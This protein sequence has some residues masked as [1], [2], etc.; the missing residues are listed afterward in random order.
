MLVCFGD[1]SSQLLAVRKTMMVKTLTD[2]Y[3]VLQLQTPEDGTVT[4][5]IGSNLMR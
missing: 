2:T 5:G 3:S 4:T 1:V